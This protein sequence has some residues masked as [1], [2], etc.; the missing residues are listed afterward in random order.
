MLNQT[1]RLKL[2][3][4]DLQR[5][6]TIPGDDEY[7][8]HLLQAAQSSLE[9]QGIHPDLSADYDQL[10]IGTA[11]WIYRKRITGEAE[12]LYLR[13]MRLDLMVCQRTKEDSACST[14]VDM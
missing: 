13:R 9:R 1:D 8:T 11:A 6:G 12:P 10:I 3:K 5:T 2:L 14:T 7:L 4:Q